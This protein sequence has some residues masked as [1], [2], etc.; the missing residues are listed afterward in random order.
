MRALSSLPAL[1]SLDLTGCEEVTDE[2]M[3]ALS[4][5]PAL[6]SLDLRHCFKVTDA[7][8]Q[9]LRNATAAPTCASYNESSPP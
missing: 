4:S 8:V 2:G 1:T 6:A 7:G 5:L 9:A 3:R